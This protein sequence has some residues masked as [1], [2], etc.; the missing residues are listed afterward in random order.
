MSNFTI[1]N[2]IIT[3][4][5]DQVTFI[6]NSMFYINLSGNHA[7]QS[8][9]PLKQQV[10]AITFEGELFTLFQNKLLNPT[11]IFRKNH[12]LFCPLFYV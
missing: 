5:L 12:S 3:K 2:V 4:F 1:F 9:S 7:H 10:R 6:Q 11:T 8:I